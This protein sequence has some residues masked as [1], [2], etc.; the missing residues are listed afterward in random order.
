MTFVYNM[1]FVSHFPEIYPLNTLRPEVLGVN[2]KRFFEYKER[3]GGL[4]STSSV[5]VL[6]TVMVRNRV[7]ATK[8]V[9]FI[10]VVVV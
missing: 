4:H 2:L 3:Q 8:C 6:E 10:H 7:M 1:I 5:R 9:I